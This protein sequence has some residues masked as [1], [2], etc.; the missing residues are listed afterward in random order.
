MRA[1]KRLNLRVIAADRWVCCGMATNFEKGNETP[2]EK[3]GQ[4]SRA[5]ETLDMKTTAGEQTE[6]STCQIEVRTARLTLSDV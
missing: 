3:P 6:T 1:A 5:A 4:D 2:R